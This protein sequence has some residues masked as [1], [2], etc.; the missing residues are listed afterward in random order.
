MLEF[1]V[2]LEAH[3]WENDLHYLVRIKRPIGTLLNCP[4]LISQ[5]LQRHIEGVIEIYKKNMVEK[6]LHLKI[7]K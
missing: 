2:S 6:K 3:D 5:E 7:V 4:P 1:N